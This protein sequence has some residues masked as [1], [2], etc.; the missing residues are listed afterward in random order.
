MHTNHG[1]LLA[2]PCFCRGDNN[3]CLQGYGAAP[4]YESPVPAEAPGPS[5]VWVLMGGEGLQRQN[6]LKSGLHVWLM[7]QNHP[8]LQVR[9]DPQ[10]SK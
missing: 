3:N 8:E 7:L 6:S 2:V 10:C 1:S 4:V 5:K 9:V